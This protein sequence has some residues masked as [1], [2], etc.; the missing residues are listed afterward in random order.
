MGDAGYS[1]KD[2]LLCLYQG[3]KYHLKKQQQAAQKPQNA[4]KLFNLRYASLRN[5]IKQ[6]FRVCKRR[7][8]ILKSTPEYD[9][10]TQIDIFFAITALHNFIIKNWHSSNEIDMYL[11]SSQSNLDDT[12]N[13]DNASDFTTEGTTSTEM[14]S[15][16][17][18]LTDQM[19]NDYQDYL[20]TKNQ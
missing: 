4:K 3:V 19:W 5:A 11:E 14:N 2:Y 12:V 18:K 17:E 20:S 9:I 8:Q 13:F 15:L 7:F 10:E 16:R 6:V 1:N